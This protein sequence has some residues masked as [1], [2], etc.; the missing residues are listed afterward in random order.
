MKTALND[1]GMEQT[2]LFTTEKD[3]MRL[4][5]FKSW[6]I[7]NKIQLYIQPIKVRFYEKDEEKFEADIMEYMKQT[8][9]E[10]KE[11][12]EPNSEF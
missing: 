10:Y 6:F 12:S 7:K 4:L 1:I 8:L 3:A 5:P 11:V 9:S 2:M